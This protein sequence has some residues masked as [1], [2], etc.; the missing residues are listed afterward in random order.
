MILSSASLALTQKMY[1]SPARAQ[2]CVGAFIYS[3]IVAEQ[4][5]I[6]LEIILLIR[7]E[8]SS[9]IFKSSHAHLLDF[10]SLRSV[11]SESSSQIS[12]LYDFPH[13]FRC[14]DM[15]QYPD[16]KGPHKGKLLYAGTRHTPHS[17]G[18]SLVLFHKTIF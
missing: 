3:T 4:T 14:C 7:G 16:Y 11:Q 2:L 15:E 10:V 5:L 13:D 12:S 8:K 6:C 9:C 1:R 17:S 18:Y